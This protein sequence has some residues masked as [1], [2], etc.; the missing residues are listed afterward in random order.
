MKKT[1]SRSGDPTEV[2]IA[3]YIRVSSQK[4]AR[5]GDSLEAQ[6]NIITKYIESQKR[7]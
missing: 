5:D 3:V 7:D 1:V 6:Q 4:Q 2:R